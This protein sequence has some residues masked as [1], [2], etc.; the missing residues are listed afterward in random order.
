[1]RTGSERGYSLLELLIVI[2][3]LGMVAAIAVPTS[4]N[5]DALKLDR[6]A[7]NVANA[8]RFARSEAIRTGKGHGLT[9]S[10]AT[11][12]VTVRAYDLTTTPI[13]TLA[14]LTHPVSKQ[15]YQFNIE[16]DPGTAG[17]I[18]KNSVDVFEYEDVGRR[19]SI[20]F[21]ASGT[22][23]WI[24]STGPIGYP[25]TEATVELQYGDQE[26]VVNVAPMTGRVS[27]Q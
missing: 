19:R 21:D 23:L 16:T 25:L 27:T 1:M 6:A 15:P 13:G 4:N 20:I 14:T 9:V 8:F 24:I 11:Q 2:A 10:Q 26:R 3:L 7:T 22:P 18:I 12:A 17:V 5:N